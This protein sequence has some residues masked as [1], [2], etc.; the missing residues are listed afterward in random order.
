MTSKVVMDLG[1]IKVDADPELLGEMVDRI[2]ADKE[3]RKAFEEDPVAVLRSRGIQVP[4]EMMKSVSPVAIKAAIDSMTEG[5]GDFR[6]A[7]VLVGVRVGT[8]PGT[9]PGVNVG[10]RVATQTRTFV[11]A[12]TEKEILATQVKELK[13][14]Q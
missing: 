11:M 1:T 4:D 7:N 3:F 5:G 10:V 2:L 14:D 9:R 12:R 6:T 13:L 8:R